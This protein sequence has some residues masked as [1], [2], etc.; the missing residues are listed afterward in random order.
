[1][2]SD[3]PLEIVEQILSWSTLVA[4]A[5]FAQTC[6]V[7][8]SLIY[9]ARDQHLWR[10]LFLADL[11]VFRVD[12]PRKCRTPLGEPLVPPGVD[13][14][15]RSGLQ[16]RVLAETIIAKPASC[17]ADELNVVLATLVGMALNTPPATAAY[18]SSE[19]SLNLVW[20]A[21]Q[22]GLGAFLEYWHAR[23]HTLTPEQRQRLAHLHTLFGLT[24][25]DFSPAHRVESR[26]YVYDMCKYRAENEWGPFRLDGSVNWEHLLAVQHVMAMY[27]V[28]P[29]KDL[30]NFTTGFL[31]Y[32]QTELPGKQTSSVRYDDWAGVEGTYTCSFC[33]IDHRVLLEFNEQEV[34]D[35]EPRDTSLF[36]ASEFLEVFRSF[37]VSMHITGTNANPRHP[38]RPDIFFKGNVHNMHTM[39]GTVRVAEDDT[40]RWS[41]TSGEDDQMI[42][43]S[44]G[45]QIGAGDPVGPF[46]LRKHTA[47]VSG[48]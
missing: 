40:I 13:F 12:D 46:W 39:V 20:L 41:F 28:M 7:Y 14:D 35:N 18:T 15:W 34:S 36:E 25:S 5:R 16:R 43:S 10:T 4:I 3:L 32:C 8:H 30:V 9:E 23:R 11:G 47:E 21:A 1:M 33:F 48:D 44:E 45:V 22:S 24:T 6:R 42:W 26:A 17:N 38:T 29:P 37:P 19:I 31:P 27:I 2:L